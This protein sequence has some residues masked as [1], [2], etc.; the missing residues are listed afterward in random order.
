MTRRN[1]GT[2]RSFVVVGI[3]LIV[4]IVV[5]VTSLRTRGLQEAVPVEPPLSDPHL[6]VGENPL[7]HAPEA[8]ADEASPF[9]AV[10]TSV[11]HRAELPVPAFSGRLRAE[12]ETAASGAMVVWIPLPES[13]M[14]VPGR[15]ARHDWNAID[16]SSLRTHSD[17][18]GSFEFDQ[19]PDGSSLLGSVLWGIHPDYLALPI[20][21]GIDS[22]EWPRAQDYHLQRVEKAYVNVVDGD[23][24]AVPGAIVEQRGIAPRSLPSE[25]IPLEHRVRDLLRTSTVTDDAGRCY[26]FAFPDEST[27]QAR[28]GFRLSAPRR[29]PRQSEVTLVLG[30]SFTAQGE[31]LG[32]EEADGIEKRP[33]VSFGVQREK[34]FEILGAVAVAEEGS[35][36]PV[37]VP[38]LADGPYRFRMEA[39]GL[40]PRDAFVDP[41]PAGTTVRVD[42][43]AIV[44]HDLWYYVTDPEGTPLLTS[45][46]TVRWDE[47]GQEVSIAAQ[48]RPDGYVLVRGCPAGPIQARA[49]APGYAPDNFQAQVAPLVHP[50]TLE[51]ALTP[52]ASLRGRCVHGGEPVD[53]FT[54]LY[55]Q[56]GDTDPPG[57]RSFDGRADGSFV[58]EQAPI[59]D[60]SLLAY[61]PGLGQS[62]SQRIAFAGEQSADVV[63]ELWDPTVGSGRV[64]D[65]M[66]GEPLG[67]AE[68]GLFATVEFGS[69]DPIVATQSV[70]PDGSFELTGFSPAP[71]TFTASA[72]GYS[73]AT[74]LIVAEA[75]VPLDLGTIALSRSQTLEIHLVGKGM[76]D[77]TRYSVHC[78]NRPEIG[79][80]VFDSEGVVKFEN[81]S[82]GEIDFRLD[83]PDNS[84]VFFGQDFVVG[85]DWKIEIPV[86]GTRQLIV[87]VAP[88]PEAEVPELGFV[89]VHYD[90]NW[91]TCKRSVTDYAFDGPVVI[92]GMPDTDLM[93]QV[94]DRDGV[95]IGLANGSFD[96]RPE[97]RLRVEIGADPQLF[98]VVDATHQPLGGVSVVVGVKRDTKRQSCGQTDARGECRLL[99]P[100]GGPL[101]AS[102]NSNTHGY[103]VGIPVVASEDPNEAIELVLTGDAEVELLL[104]DGDRPVAGLVCALEDHFLNTGT[105]I[106]NLTSDSQGQVAWDQLSPGEF[107]L[108]AHHPDYLPV[109]EIVRASPDAA[110]VVIQVRQ[111]GRT[112]FQ[113][114]SQS[115]RPVFDLALE[116][117]NLEFQKN[118]Q[119]WIDIDYV[120]PPPRG[121]VTDATGRLFLD[122]L[123]H[124]DYRWRVR[125]PG[126]DPVEGLF[127]VIAGGEVHVSVALP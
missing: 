60:L 95:T 126:F 50:V 18:H 5:L 107:L 57:R 23:G 28:Q 99:V 88:S 114:T 96:G 121:L 24:H 119:E 6:E 37:T 91:A 86:K 116:L 84:S 39:P 22:S 113:A 41:P 46:V 65:Q 67:T 32:W 17:T 127:T 70:G 16:A 27:L 98:R 125:R 11:G 73:T 120:L 103:R 36:G 61:A 104:R 71:T 15:V 33:Q 92:D 35:W 76:V 89:V 97:L 112:T 2:A 29:G 58:L 109:R 85:Y 21:L 48:P 45:T 38:L 102:L 42:F 8:I 77:P 108:R 51:L 55:W 13:V 1:G 82:A 75:G 53:E 47:E 25:E 54:V 106:P 83:L 12:G 72:K 117:T 90:H 115:G 78:L 80:A 7:D 19:E 69:F 94:Q 52:A 31:L 68:V 101:F 118:V 44:G 105:W 26:F 110:P 74:R 81:V 40:V 10:E 4:T 79:S 43:E 9:R 49:L 87:D 14:E 100:T 59:G 123:P 34:R 93:V 63:I 30:A 20:L 62:E 3:V 66:T 124:G 64:I 56:T 111:T 122:D